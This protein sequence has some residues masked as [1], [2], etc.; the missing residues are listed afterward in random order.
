MSAAPETAAVFPQGATPSP[1]VA[2][3]APAAAALSQ[4]HGAAPARTIGREH[5]PPALTPFVLRI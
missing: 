2:A 3:H 5:S 1:A 4:R